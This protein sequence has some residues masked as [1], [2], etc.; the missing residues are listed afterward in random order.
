M[1]M[2]ILRYGLFEGVTKDEKLRAHLMAEERETPGLLRKRLSQID[3]VSAEKIHPNDVKR[4]IRALEVYLLSGK[5]FSK[6]GQQRK[7]DERF[8]LIFL[9]PDRK[10][11]Y[12][13]INLR[14]ER[15]VERGLIDETSELI[16]RYNPKFQ[17]MK[18]IGY[19]ETIDYLSGQFATKKDYIDTLKKNTR[20]F[21][22]RQIIW[23]RRY[24]EAIKFDMKE[25]SESEILTFIEKQISS[26][27]SS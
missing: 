1:Y 21:A 23:S 16:K 18:A 10:K 13:T 2:D 3:P 25:K 24:D 17:S 26:F 8:Q 7:A 5:T 19:R 22:K 4:T 11:L 6:L 12:E 20:H 9:L 14:V 27:F 15:M